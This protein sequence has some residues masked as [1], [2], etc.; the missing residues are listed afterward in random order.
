VDRLAAL[1]SPLNTTLNGID[2][3]EMTTADQRHLTVH[4]LTTVPVAGSLGSPAVTITGG[5]SV[6]TVPV[7][8]IDAGADWTLDAAGR[9]LLALSVPYPGDFS[10]YTLTV[11]S[12]VLD[13]WFSSRPFTF[14][15]GCPSTLDCETSPPPCPVP[16]GPRP[17]IDYLAKDYLSFRQALSDM[18]AD[19]YPAWV[20]RDE[21]DIG[22]MV[23]EL[24]S[25]VADDL[26]YQQDR[27]AAEA[28]LLT[29][30]ERRSLLRLARLV[31]F[32]PPPALS[33]TVLLQV[34]VTSGPLPAGTVMTAAL[35]DGTLLDFEVGAGLVDPGTG[36]ASLATAPVDPRWNRD[37]AAGASRILPYFWDDS[38][39]CL[40]VGA[41]EMWVENHGFGFPTGDPASDMA[42]L[43]ILIDTAAA[44]PLDDPIREIVHLSAA[45]EEVDPLTRTAVT[46][47]RWPS[48]DALR[49]QHDL[50]RT[51]LAGNIVTATEG[52]RHIERFVIPPSPPS[53]GGPGGAPVPAVVRTGSNS[54]CE[55]PV[56]MYL[57]TLTAGR[58]AWLAS[59]PEGTPVPEILV[60]GQGPDDGDPRVAWP[61]MRSLL[62][63]PE[64]DECFTV[65]P[66]R[67]VDLRA[68]SGLPPL[69]EYDGDGGDSIRFGDTD[70]GQQPVPGTLFD[71]TYRVGHGETGNVGADTIV[72]F[73]PALAGILRRVTNPF[74][75]AGG[76]DPMA[77]E[78]VQ[79]VAPELFR[80]VLYRAVRP[81]DYEQAATSLPWVLQANTVFRWTGSWPTVFTTADPRAAEAI[82]VTQELGLIDLLNRRRLAGYESYALPPHYIGADLVVTVCAEPTS[83]KAAV[84]AAVMVELGTTTRADG[85]PAFFASDHFGLGAPLERSS[86]DAAIQRANGVQGVV[87]ILIRRRW[88]DP[89][90]TPIPEL[91]TVG[92]SDVIRVDN[93]A[94]RPERGSLR[95]VVEGGK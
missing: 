72:G 68:G 79:V 87:S 83:F 39:R 85:Q 23:M 37:D 8:P 81:E 28:S 46:H 60:F 1:L 41:T 55:S 74:P 21:P 61:F 73:S 33:A 76:A 63:A 26:S 38:A 35:P 70:F 10:I 11:A 80:T 40:S 29:A 27:V 14:K 19:W 92:V 78:R 88:L 20:E 82:A 5:E 86:L 12:T 54:T 91:V 31:D 95:V 56:P 16:D 84:K 50:T 32:E 45:I 69:W 62:D 65:D 6:A 25:S 42:G 64:N 18:S 30:T 93:D 3:V 9:P 90:F 7:L 36:S 66:V 58:L 43:A 59:G 15:A 77:P 24:L 49:Q 67:Y 4:F 53:P 89:G 75:A 52:R 17:P 51:R 47:L 34:D 71:V 22:M 57:H 48:S 2:F 44:S 94:S 13:P